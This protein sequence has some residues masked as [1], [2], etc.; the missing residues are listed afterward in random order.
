MTTTSID[1]LIKIQQQIRIAEKYQ[2]SEPGMVTPGEILKILRKRE[3]DLNN[4]LQAQM[5]KEAADAVASV[6][7]ADIAEGNAHVQ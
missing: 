3:H 7:A 4:E 6:V 2:E 1:S 5:L